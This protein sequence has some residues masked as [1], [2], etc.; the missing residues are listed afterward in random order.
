MEY[1]I[2]TSSSPDELTRR[3]NELIKDG[4]KPVGGHSVVVTHS[5]NRFSGTQHM[6]TRHQTEYSQTIVKE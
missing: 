6:D 2:L 1:K 4:W 3:V 5:Q